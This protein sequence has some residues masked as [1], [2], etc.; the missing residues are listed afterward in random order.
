MERTKSNKIYNYK[1]RV[2]IRSFLTIFTIATV[3]FGSLATYVFAMVGPDEIF[4]QGK[5]ESTSRYQDLIDMDVQTLRGSLEARKPFETNGELDMN[6]TIDIMDPQ[7]TDEKKQNQNTTFTVEDITNM[8]QQMVFDG[9]DRLDSNL[10]ARDGETGEYLVYKD[11]YVYDDS[12]ELSVT[13]ALSEEE[14]T[15]LLVK[16]MKALKLATP[17]SGKPLMEYAD[18]NQD[19]VTPVAVFEALRDIKIMMTTYDDFAQQSSTVGTNLRYYIKDNEANQII[20]NGNWKSVEAAAKDTKARDVVIECKRG[21]NGCFISKE[22]TA[23]FEMAKQRIRQQPLI[24]DSEE[25]VI[26]VDPN[27]PVPDRLSE[28]RDAYNSLKPYFVPFLVL[29]IISLIGMILCFILATITTGQS[30]KKGAVC[31]NVF[32]RIPTEIGAG[33]V[34]LLGLIALGVNIGTYEMVSNSNANGV[35]NVLYMIA[36]LMTATLIATWGFLSLVRRIKAKD[37]WKNSLCRRVLGIAKKAYRAGK[38]NTRFVVAFI[39]FV[40]ANIFLTVLLGIPGLILLL[41]GDVAILVELLKKVDERQKIKDGLDIL[42]AGNLDYKLDTNNLQQDNQ[43]MAE[44]VNKIADG[45]QSAVEKSM[46]NERM[47]SELITNVSHDIKT[48]LTSIINYVDLLKREDINNPQVKGYIDILDAKSQ[49]LKHLTEDLVEASKV[50]S[51]NIELH[52]DNLFVQELLQQAEGEVGEKLKA[53]KLELVSTLVAE[54]IIIK[55]DGRQMWR[56]FENLFNNIA[57]YALEGTRVYVDLIKEGKKAT[58]MFKNMSQEPLNI[59]ADELTE[60]FVR[61]DISRTTEGSGLG[62]SIAKSLTELQGG[63]FDIYLDGDL[64]KVTLAF[65]TV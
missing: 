19:G 10:M 4:S 63:K 7:D 53:R 2:I 31:L 30:E 61:G 32:D 24:S 28:F 54:P 52:M 46:K 44:S 50:S 55:A 57:K 29:A 21:A 18:S 33:I 6:K 65:D 12:N 34:C 59:S 36:M 1:N 20:T 14:H 64:F 11:E 8:N 16:Q 35:T 45:L 15:S 25:I 40:L 49:R 9:I 51:G 17:I 58:L 42:A 43:E 62:L 38:M 37:V 26:T 39:V 13:G 23:G 22:S 41:I 5:V 3:I 47:R 56:I 60:R 27:Y 48:P